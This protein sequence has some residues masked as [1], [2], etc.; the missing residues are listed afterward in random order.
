M[1]LVREGIM[2]KDEFNS[3]YFKHQMGKIYYPVSTNS[4]PFPSNEIPEC[5]DDAFMG[6]VSSYLNGRKWCLQKIHSG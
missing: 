1:L 3:Y 2:E 5:I 6:V 4:F